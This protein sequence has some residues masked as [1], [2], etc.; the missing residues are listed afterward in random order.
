M[1]AGPLLHIAGG[2][3]LLLLALK[4]DSILAILGP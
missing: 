4:K 2:A 1:L 3:I